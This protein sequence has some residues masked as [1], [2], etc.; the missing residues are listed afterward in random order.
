MQAIDIQRALTVLG[1][2]GTDAIKQFQKSIGFTGKDIDGIAGPKTRAKLL[3]IQRQGMISTDAIIKKFGQ[4]GDTKNFKLITLPYP[5]RIAWDLTMSITKMQVH[6]LVADQLLTIYKELLD[7]Y[8]L[9]E[10]QAL[11]IDLYGGCY[12]FRKMRGGTSWSRHSWAIAV[13][14]DPARNQLHER[15]NTA[16]FARPEYLP[17]LL[18]FYKHGFVNQGVE[19]GFDFMH[20]QVAP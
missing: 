7:V 10:L 13:D 9:A 15:A 19:L 20:F 4:P 12:N 11:G 14:H 8:G 3:T 1:F 17:M 5:Q 16:R 6:K 18:I 2:C